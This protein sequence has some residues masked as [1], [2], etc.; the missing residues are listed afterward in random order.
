MKHRWLLI[1]ALIA[2]LSYPLGWHAALSVTESQMWK[3]AGVALLALWAAAKARD[4]DGWLIAAVMAL[5]A[6]GDVLLELSQIGGALAFLAGHLVAILLYLRNRRERPS[7]SQRLLAILVI[8]LGTAIA[9]LLPT[10]RAAAPAIAVYALGLTAMVAAAW[11]SRFP[12]YRVG[13]GAVMFMVSDLLIFARLGPL[14]GVAG[15][16]LAI[17]LLYFVGQAMVATGVVGAL[18]GRQ[19]GEAP[20]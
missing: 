1:A 8:P 19:A 11:T 15:V 9:F 14:A 4:T 2:G 20:H 13:L 18:A 17:W 7:A 3:G 5:G 12:R 6:L 16:G 10:D